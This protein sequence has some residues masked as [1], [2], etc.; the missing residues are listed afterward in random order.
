MHLVYQAFNP[1]EPLTY[2][3]N[4]KLGKDIERDLWTLKSFFRC[5]ALLC[6]KSIDRIV[7]GSSKKDTPCM[8][9]I[10]MSYENG[11]LKIICL[12]QDKKVCDS[13][14]QLVVKALNKV[15]NNDAIDWKAVREILKECSG[16]KRNY[17]CSD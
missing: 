12:L 5:Y 16:S 13:I 11:K 7:F 3:V 9:R 6:D 17:F 10:L 2:F 8:S 15:S 14:Y 1:K 4:I